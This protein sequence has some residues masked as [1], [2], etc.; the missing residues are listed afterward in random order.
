[1][2]P[3]NEGKSQTSTSDFSSPEFLNL[4]ARRFDTAHFS[5]AVVDVAAKL[6]PTTIKL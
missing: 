5:V 6:V 1:M 2:L 4:P 3:Q